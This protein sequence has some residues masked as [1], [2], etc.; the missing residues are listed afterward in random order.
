MSRG[1]RFASMWWHDIQVSKNCWSFSQSIDHAN[2]FS[3][4]FNFSFTDK[5][6]LEARDNTT[7]MD[8]WSIHCINE[9]GLCNKV[10]VVFNPPK[11]IILKEKQIHVSEQFLAACH[12]FCN[13]YIRLLWW[14]TDYII[15]TIISL[16]TITIIWHFTGSPFFCG[17]RHS[18][19]RNLCCIFTWEESICSIWIFFGRQHSNCT[20]CTTLLQF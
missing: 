2:V 5:A 4:C 10:C 3:N 12:I 11:S 18:N 19:F 20:K 7:W 8:T 17:W 9:N 14:Y 6:Q 16:F 15:L 13:L 1:T